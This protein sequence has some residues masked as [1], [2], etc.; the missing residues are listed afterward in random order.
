M[1]EYKQI[2]FLKVRESVYE[3]YFLCSEKREMRIGREEKRRLSGAPGFVGGALVNVN[4]HGKLHHEKWKS[5]GDL[6]RK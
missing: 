5:G 2:G 3:K 6:G 4:F 1:N